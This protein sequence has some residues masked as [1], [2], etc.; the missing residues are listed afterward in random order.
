MP[1]RVKQAL[2]HCPA[3]PAVGAEALQPGFVTVPGSGIWLRVP[4][5]EAARAV[6]QALSEG[7]W[8]VLL[9][10]VNGLDER[11]AARALG[12]KLGTVKSQG[13]TARLRASQVL[14][15]AFGGGSASKRLS[16]VLVGFLPAPALSGGPAVAPPA[17][18]PGPG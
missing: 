11:A 10:M 7:E 14:G 15:V 9:A 17:S 16:L 5:S 1:R 13:R 8:R 3:G 4:C 2:I 12:L 18:P 6:R